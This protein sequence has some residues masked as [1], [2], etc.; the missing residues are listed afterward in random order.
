MPF[1]VVGAYMKTDGSLLSA[2]KVFQ[3]WDGRAE[4]RASVLAHDIPMTHV[5][6]FVCLHL[7]VSLDVN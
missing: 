7:L 1:P 5:L 3:R 4:S 2:L 6:C